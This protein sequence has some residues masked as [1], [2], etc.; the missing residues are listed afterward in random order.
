M[1]SAALRLSRRDL[2]IDAMPD[3]EKPE[4]FD[5]APDLR[6]DAPFDPMTSRPAQ[7]IRSTQPACGTKEAK[8]LCDRCGAEVYRMHA[9]WRCPECGFKS[10][11]CGW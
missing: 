2:I 7:P 6:S 10:D 9:V 5:T 3:R 4:S 1:D 11:C 8:T